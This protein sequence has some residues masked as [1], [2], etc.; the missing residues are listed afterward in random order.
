MAISASLPVAHGA[1]APCM[2]VFVETWFA[3][4]LIGEE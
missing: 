2:M 3:Y 4:F 1:D